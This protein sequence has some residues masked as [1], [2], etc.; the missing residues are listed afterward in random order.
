[1]EAVMDPTP[2]SAPR[3]GS[4]ETL[5][6][7]FSCLAF[8][9]LYREFIQWQ[10]AQTVEAWEDMKAIYHEHLAEPTEVESPDDPE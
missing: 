9:Y 1:M 5:A 3:G 6:V 7:V 4:L 10:K 2:P 8:V